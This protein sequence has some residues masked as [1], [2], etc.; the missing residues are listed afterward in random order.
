MPARNPYPILPPTSAA[1]GTSDETWVE[2]I[3][4]AWYAQYNGNATFTLQGSADQGANWAD[5]Q[6]CTNGVV[7]A[8]SASFAPK[9]RV[10]WTG[11]TGEQSVFLFHD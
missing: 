6:T 9:M 10:V 5:L 1:S 3:G 7:E 11:G 8:K 4:K 2:P